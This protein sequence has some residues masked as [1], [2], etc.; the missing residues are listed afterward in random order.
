M[1]EENDFNKD[2]I[3]GQKGTVVNQFVR[4]REGVIYLVEFD[5]RFNDILISSDF[6]YGK[7]P[8]DGKCWL[9]LPD[10]MRKIKK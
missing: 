10:E 5:N 7:K 6:V 2:E 9:I 8:G 4:E 1:V 3:I